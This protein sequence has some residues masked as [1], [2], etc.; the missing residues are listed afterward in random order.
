MS[1][2]STSIASQIRRD[3]KADAISAATQGKSLAQIAELY[4]TKVDTASVISYELN[5]V[6]GAGMEPALVGK[7]AASE[8]GKVFS[9]V[10]GNNGAYAF[11]ITSEQSQSITDQQV[12][13][14]Y[15]Q[16]TMQ[17]PYLIHQVVTDVDIEDNRIRFY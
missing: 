4:N 5:S 14:A 3:K 7:I 17:L 12:R 11:A 10:K 1:D 16:K 13:A 9:A 6:P 15:E 8:A 2:V